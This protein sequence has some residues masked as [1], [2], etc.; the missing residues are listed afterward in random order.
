[1]RS[2]FAEK[3]A[4]FMPFHIATRSGGPLAGL[5]VLVVEASKF[6]SEALRL[7][8]LSSGARVRQASGVTAA[9]RH[10]RAYRP[11][12]LITEMC[13]PDGEG[14]SLITNLDKMNPRLSVI[15]GM[16]AQVDDRAK[17]IRA[18]ADGFILKPFESVAIFQHAIKSALPPELQQWK[19]V[20]ISDEQIVPDGLMLMQDMAHG[21][22]LLT[23]AGTPQAI[24][25]AATFIAG[26]AAVADDA[27]FH[28]SATAL[29]VKIRTGKHD[30]NDIAPV[31]AMLKQRLDSGNAAILPLHPT[32]GGRLL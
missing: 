31:Q 32:S 7:L 5:T 17:A 29:M 24:G 19:P 20:R 15:L 12:I 16:S 23:S 27:E 21:L 10:L 9:M 30:L 4:T 28:D 2:E 25:Y 8:C 1:M 14:T 26:V 11:D 13:L 3:P 22:V 6:S 18:G